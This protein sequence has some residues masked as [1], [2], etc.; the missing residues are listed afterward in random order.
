MDAT[1]IPRMAVVT[2]VTL[3]CVGATSAVIIHLRKNGGRF[4]LFLL[5]AIVTGVAIYC[6]VFVLL[7]H[8]LPSRK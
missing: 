8:S 2:L 4:S 7:W 6:E 5:L 1:W 3:L